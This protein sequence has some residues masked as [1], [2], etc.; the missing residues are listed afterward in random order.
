MRSDHAHF[1][2]L[3]AAN[4]KAFFAKGKRSGNTTLHGLEKNAVTGEIV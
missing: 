4:S 3:N 1:R 2:S